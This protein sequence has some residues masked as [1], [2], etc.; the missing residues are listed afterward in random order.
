[1]R[2]RVKFS[3]SFQKKLTCA[4]RVKFGF[5]IGHRGHRP[6]L[7]ARNL[8]SAFEHA[9]FVDAHLEQSIA[10]G[11]TA[12][13]FSSPPLPSMC[14][15]G[16]GIVPK[17]SGKLRLFHHLS[18]PAGVSVNDGIPKGLYSLQYVTIDDAIDMILR[19]GRGHCWQRLTFATP[20]SMP[21]ATRGPAPP[22]YLLPPAILP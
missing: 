17:K 3:A 14:C 5:G 7:T 11:H 18:A 9:D 21:R 20:S 19:L 1:M 22:W 12:G 16:V 6:A 4:H 10:A 8:R 2:D 15:S 13:P